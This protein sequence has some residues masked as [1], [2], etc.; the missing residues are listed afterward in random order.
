MG[1]RNAR[2]MMLRAACSAIVFVV[3]AYVAGRVQ[4]LLSGPCAPLRNGGGDAVFPQCVSPAPAVGVMV[5][6]GAVAAFLTWL[7][8]GRLLRG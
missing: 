5:L 6:A 4:L 1:R 7:L 8:A 3:A 2:V